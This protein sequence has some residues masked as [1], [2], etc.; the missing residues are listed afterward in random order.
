MGTN[1]CSGCDHSNRRRTPQRSMQGNRYPHTCSILA[2]FTDVSGYLLLSMTSLRVFFS[3]YRG[4]TLNGSSPCERG[5][6][7]QAQTVVQD[8]TTV[9]GE[10]HP[11]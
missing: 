4:H 11:Q 8:V 1:R 6:L 10:E 3:C 7:S 9:T 2:V 5:A